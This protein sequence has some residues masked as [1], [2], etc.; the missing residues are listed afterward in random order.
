MKSTN[1]WPMNLTAGRTEPC[2]DD[3][4]SSWRQGSVSKTAPIQALSQAYLLVT[5][6]PCYRDNAGVRW[7]EQTWHHDL[8]EHLKYL[9][10]FTLCAP[11]LPK[12]AEPN[13]VPVGDTK[14]TPLQHIDLPPQTS[15]LQAVAGL[16]R[17]LV[18]LWSAI[19][20]SEIVHSA[21]IGWPYPLGW[22]ANPVAIARGKGLVIVV[23]SSWR[24]GGESAEAQTWKIKGMNA[25]TDFA[26]RWSCKRAHV[27]LFTHSTYRDTLHC[28]SRANSYVTPAVWINETDILD[29]L[30]AERSWE[31]KIAKPVRMLFAG[32]LIS[33]K[34]VDVLLAAL[35]LLD[36]RGVK[37]HIDIIGQGER[38]QPCAQAAGTFRNVLLSVLD[39]IPY[40]VP[41]F[42][43]VRGYHALLLPSL[44]DEQP[45]VIFDANSQAVPVIASDTAGIR[46]HV[47]HDRTGWL[48]PSGKPRSLAMMLERA[49]TNPN[50]LR[51][52]GM[53][54]LSG[55][56]G[57][58]HAAMHRTRFCILKR[59]FV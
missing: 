26:A 23:E 54:A 36:D 5:S 19:G 3:Q 8:M 6:I 18:T 39:P 2:G 4:P 49:M 33:G 17:T 46:P 25:A 15:F 12:R 50:E 10:H 55:T 7:L 58:T 24:R 48:L 20:K 56:R 21:V 34:G 32:R 30:L 51:S 9:R 13:L 44:T 59:H 57:H 27:A 11:V 29:D 41:F 52:M 43:L 37:A 42:E 16:P 1:G 40:G 47:D 38:R 28:T 45:R 14:D 35:R 31:E 53:A 22:I